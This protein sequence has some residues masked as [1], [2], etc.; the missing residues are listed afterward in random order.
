MV[1]SNVFGQIQNILEN[2]VSIDNFTFYRLHLLSGR[3]FREQR[4]TLILKDTHQRINIADVIF[5]S[6]IEPWYHPWIELTYPYDLDK[7]IEGKRFVYFN[8][9]IEKKILELFCKCLPPAGKLFVSYETD[10]ETRKGLMMNIPPVITRLGYLLFIDGCT[11][12]K[13]WYF[14]EGGL[15]GGQKLQGEKPFNKSD[16]KRHF[17]QIR[18]DVLKFY[19]TD[20]DDGSLSLYE[21]KA[22][23]R[24]KMILSII[25]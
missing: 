10:D 8:S 24:S 20:I 17:K 7:E 23:E 11:W 6:G 14:P 25:G 15:E 1:N 22:V 18:H 21:K 4:T 19:M 5:F 16:K 2:G 13:D 3:S 9:S 12:F